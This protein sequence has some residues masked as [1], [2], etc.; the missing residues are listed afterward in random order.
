MK[1][2]SIVFSK[3]S[4][5]NVF[6]TLIMWG[7]KTPFSHVSIKTVDGDTGQTIYY[8]SS[9]LVVNCVSE[10]EFLSAETVVYEKDIQASDKV[11]V[12]GKTWAINQL[13]KP[14]DAMAILGFAVQILLGMA[15]I[16]IS[17]P[18]KA[19]GSEYVCSQFAGAFIDTCEN[20]Q[21]DITNLTPSALYEQM[22]NIP[23]VWS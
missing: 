13:G 4:S 6:S 7:L 23:S 20:I 15:H 3:R 5:F 21:L 10:S 19:N 12:A 1:P 9:G 16:K 14:Y 17:N 11:F 18:F 2:I 8:Q 22:P